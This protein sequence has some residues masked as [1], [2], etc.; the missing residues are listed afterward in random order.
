MRLG[1]TAPQYSKAK[2]AVASYRMSAVRY[3][4]NSKKNLQSDTQTFVYT[5]SS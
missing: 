2:R 4:F 1:F 5:A 3:E